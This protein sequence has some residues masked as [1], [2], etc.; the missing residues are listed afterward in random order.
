MFE[1]N[2]AERL[3]EMTADRDHW[4][5]L[6][7]E[8]NVVIGTLGQE[9]ERLRVDLENATL[10][11][12]Q[13]RTLA[14]QYLAHAEQL[15]TQVAAP[16]FQAR[17]ADWIHACFGSE[18]ASNHAERNHRF[19]EEALEFVQAGGCSKSEALQLLD[20]VYGRPA[21]VMSQ[22]VGGVMVTLAAL[23]SAFHLD[24]QFCAEEEITRVW[25]RMPEIRAKQAAKPKYSALPTNERHSGK[26]TIWV[27]NPC[28]GEHTTK[29]TACL[30][31]GSANLRP[32]AKSP[33]EVY[34]SAVRELPAV[35]HVA[36]TDN[37]PDPE[38]KIGD[39][40]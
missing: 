40:S 12:I 33:S 10:A 2:E 23:C 34:E 11:A 35:T 18:I 37:P 31:C 9:N 25:I 39:G 21:G 24:M 19:L 6:A 30:R 17:V 3:A 14:V 22:E 20:Y 26:L 38:C 1:L 8:R 28:G 4:R 13:N 5:R 7:S 32:A 27:C 36:L 15:R 29:V 16:S